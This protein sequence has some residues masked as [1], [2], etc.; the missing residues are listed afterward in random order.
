MTAGFASRPAHSF[1][2]F[3]LAALVALAIAMQA[4]F[5]YALASGGAARGGAP[6]QVRP[7]PCATG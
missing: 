7:Q 2:P 5:V 3:V 4:A 1:E 6:E